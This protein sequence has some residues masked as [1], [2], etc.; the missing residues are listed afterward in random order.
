LAPLVDFPS[1]EF[2]RGRHS[3]DDAILAELACVLSRHKA[4][5]RFGIILLCRP[6]ALPHGITS[7]NAGCSQP[8]LL[9]SLPV[10]DRHL[11]MDVAWQLFPGR[12]PV[13]RCIAYAAKPTYTPL[14]LPA[15]NGS[16]S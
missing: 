13:A 2:V 6:H 11:T 8:F 12:D 1:V 9:A 15:D 5:R 14:D 7:A 16:W 3:G 10:P 4:E